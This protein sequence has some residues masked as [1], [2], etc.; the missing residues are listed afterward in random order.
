MKTLIKISL[1]AG[2]FLAVCTVQV[3]AQ[4]VGAPYMPYVK[5]VTIPANLTLG[6]NAK[7]MLASIYDADYLPYT[8]P[9]ATA[10]TGAVAADGTAESTVINV[11]GSISTTGV[12]VYIPATATGSGILGVYSTTITVPAGM[13]EDGVSRNL[14]LSWAAQAYTKASISITATLAAVGGTFNAKKLDINGGMGNDFLGV[15]LGSFSYPYNNAG[16]TT[17]YQVRDMAGIPDRMFGK[18][19][20]GNTSTYEH[21][22]IYVPVVGEDGN[23][24]LNNNL[25][26]D[27]ANI[28][29][30]SFSPAT[31]ATAY[32]DYHAYGSLFQW[33]RC[34]DGHELIS[35]STGT[36]GTLKYGTTT[37]LSTT[38]TPN[39][40]LFITN[41]SSPYDWRSTQNDN[42]WQGEAGTNNPCPSGFRVPTNAELTSLVTAVGITNSATAAASKLRFSV[43]GYRGYNSGA[44]NYTGSEGYYWSSSVNGA[45]AYSRSFYN[46]ITGTSYT[47]RAHGFTVRCLGN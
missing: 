36:T 10:I 1:I 32:N 18:Y 47:D 25:G 46:G 24:W 35:W 40:A 28:S 42:L 4:M 20:I 33:G 37:T 22:F 16:A 11:Q 19:D 2:L 12:T 41:T 9:T 29:S 27:Y 30:S 8:T 14:T 34:P 43:P 13:T 44:L 21:N 39:S 5:P 31:Q 17:T 26:A 6:Q 45:Y 3:F 38:D 7:Y 15:L 23:I